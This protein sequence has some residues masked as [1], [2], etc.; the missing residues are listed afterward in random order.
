MLTEVFVKVTSLSK[1]FLETSEAKGVMHSFFNNV[2]N[3]LFEIN[4]ERKMIT[5]I[6][7]GITLLPDSI[8]ISDVIFSILKTQQKCGIIKQKYVLKLE[9]VVLFLK[10][11]ANVSLFLP[12]RIHSI[13]KSRWINN[14][15]KIMQWDY[16]FNKKS[17]LGRLPM[18]FSDGV[19]LFAKGYLTENKKMIIDSFSEIIGAGYGLTPSCDDAMLGIM[20]GACTWFKV[21]E[22]VDGKNKY[23][24][25]SSEILEKLIVENS[26]TEV[27]RKYLKCACRGDFSATLCSLMEWTSVV[28]TRNV[29]PDEW[30]E[31]IVKTGHTS[32]MD[33][34]YGV[35]KIF[36][37]VIGCIG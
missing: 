7:E 6:K 33:M 2:V 4:G 28:E 24:E 11:G 14:T 3:L 10:P 31:I 20:A 37:E 12:D 25:L 1:D 16:P 15:I 26:T 19:E 29:K 5:L 35:K 17:D 36:E 22:G 32:G 9:E 8:V 27:S 34:L 21:K 13:S 23:H 18:K 30:I